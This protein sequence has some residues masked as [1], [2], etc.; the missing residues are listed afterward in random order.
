MRTT[1]QHF[2][3]ECIDAALQQ[4][5]HDQIIVS[6]V[7]DNGIGRHFLTLLRKNYSTTLSA[8]CETLIKHFAKTG[9]TL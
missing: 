4:I 6:K 2:R 8:L 7:R 9:A 1:E 5:V 3:K